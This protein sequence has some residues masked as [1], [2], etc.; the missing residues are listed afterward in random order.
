MKNMPGEESNGPGTVVGVNVALTGTLKDQNDI[1]VHGM[2]DGEVVSEKTVTV[3]QTAQVKGPVKGQLIMV[4]G[5]VRGSIEAGEKLEVIQTGKIYGSIHTKD[6][7]VHSGATII[8]KVTM[9]DET[10]EPEVAEEP[11]GEEP[12]TE[13]EPEVETNNAEDALKPDEE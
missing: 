5:V 2:V 6:L 4:A 13:A 10:E 3:G 7:V 11:A 1:V 8:G 9:R 12:L